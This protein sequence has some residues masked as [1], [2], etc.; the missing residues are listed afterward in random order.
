[1]NGYR[2]R[3]VEIQFDAPD[4]TNPDDMQKMLNITER[5]GGLTPNTAKELTYTVLGKDGC[6]D[7][8]GDW[9]DIPLAYAK[10]TSQGQMQQEFSGN[11]LGNMQEGKI[12]STEENTTYQ[13]S[14][15]MVSEDEMQQL[16]NQIQKASVRDKDILPVMLEI[17]KALIGYQQKAGE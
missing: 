7:Y 17:R 3:Y 5:A 9:G 13:Q 16:D 12:K 8:E 6:E 4:I 15:I 1:M 2:F 11:V 14:K 10:T